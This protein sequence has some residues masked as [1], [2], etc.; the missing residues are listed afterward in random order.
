MLKTYRIQQTFQWDGI[1]KKVQRYVSECLVYLTHKCS[2]LA[3]DGMLKPL[4]V[5][6]NVWEDINMDFIEVLYVSSGINVILVVVDRS[7]KFG[8]FIGLKHFFTEQV[9]QGNNHIVWLS[10]IHS[11]RS[12]HDISEELLKR[13]F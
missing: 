12:R 1:R 10:F 3:H 8:H 6:A 13:V 9:C 2:T 11:L 4:L 5:P 7:R